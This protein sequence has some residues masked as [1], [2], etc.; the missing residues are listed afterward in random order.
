MEEFS[1][2]V[3]SC[4]VD[5]FFQVDSSWSNESGIEFL[6][7]IRREEEDTLRG[8]GSDTVESVQESRKGHVTVEAIESNNLKSVDALSMEPIE[9]KV[10]TYPASPVCCRFEKA[11]SISSNKTTLLSGA[12]ASR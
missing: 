4:I 8:R 1:S 3:G 12:F 11:A 6:E 2:L 7:V 9:D 10:D 5:Q